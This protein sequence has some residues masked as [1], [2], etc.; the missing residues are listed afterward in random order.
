MSAE[1]PITPACVPAILSA[2]AIVFENDDQVVTSTIIIAQETGNEHASVIK[3][4]RAYLADFEDFGLVRFEIQPRPEGQHGGGDVEY[5]L[6]NEHQSTLLI[7]Y[8]R[9]SE[10]VRAFKKRL[11]KAFFEFAQSVATQLPQDYL[12]ALKAL[13]ESEEAKQLALAQARALTQQLETDKPYT[14][15]A[16]AITGQSTM[17]RRDW[18]ALMKTDHGI[19]VGEREL[20]AWMIDEGYCY[21]DALTR[22]LRAYAHHADL[23]KLE[24]H[25]I[26]GFPRK[27]LMV[28]GDGVFRL[29]PIVVAAFSQEDAA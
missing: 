5:A 29:T 1:N 19:Q 26:S 25:V 27:L 11:V 22:E 18:C 17:T 13:V 9:N 4:V 7:T 10:V 3:L 6:L 28:T 14:E 2:H 15:L 21:R 23:F 20:T 12:S 8:M 16:R 24:V